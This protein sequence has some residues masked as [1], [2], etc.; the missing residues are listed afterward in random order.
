MPKL[1]A[2]TTSYTKATSTIEGIV[3]TNILQG[4]SWVEVNQ[5]LADDSGRLYPMLVYALTEQKEDV[6]EENPNGVFNLSWEVK[7]KND[8]TMPSGYLFLPTS[9]WKKGF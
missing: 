7:N 9:Q 3:D 6:S 2:D 5:E 8:I 4:K 1:P